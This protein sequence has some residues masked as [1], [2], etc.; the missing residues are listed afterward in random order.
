MERYIV[1]YNT[2]RVQQQ[3]GLNSTYMHLLQIGVVQ[4]IVDTQ[5]GLIVVNKKWEWFKIP[6][7]SSPDL[8]I[9]T[10]KQ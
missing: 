2:G 5:E 1:F 6:E 3:K 4:Q 9:Q 8:I 10:K 7:Y